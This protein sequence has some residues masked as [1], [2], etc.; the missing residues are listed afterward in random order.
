[1]N[2]ARRVLGKS[3]DPRPE[4]PEVGQKLSG[5]DSQKSRDLLGVKYHTVKE[6]TEYIL[7]EFKKR[8]WA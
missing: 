8:D 5:F 3:G 2:A 1:M 7:D 6:T 4:T